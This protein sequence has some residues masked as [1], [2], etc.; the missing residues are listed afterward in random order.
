MKRIF[1]LVM[2][3]A[4]T[5][6]VLAQS[7]EPSASPEDGYRHHWRH[8]RERFLERLNLSEQQR[9]QI[10]KFRSDNKGAFRTAMLNF[11]TAERTLQ[12]AIY[13]NPTDEAT[14]SSLSASANSARTQLTIQRAKLQAMIGGVLTPEQRQTWDQ[15]HQKRQDRMQKRIERL[16]QST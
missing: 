12:D 8:G 6:S 11:L 13:K 14:I 4:T 5:V 2:L 3:L 1:W 9:D 16:S 10:K 15:M 7:S